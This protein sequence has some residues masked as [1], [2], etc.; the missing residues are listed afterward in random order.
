MIPPTMSGEPMATVHRMKILR[1]CESDTKRVITSVAISE[2]QWESI[3]AE[4]Q[5]A[6]LTVDEYVKRRIERGKEI[7]DAIER[8]GKDEVRRRIERGQGLQ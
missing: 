2:R 1:F 6:G 8:L 4:A 3:C 7:D 5:R